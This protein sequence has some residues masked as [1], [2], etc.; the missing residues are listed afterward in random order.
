MGDTV[1]LPLEDYFNRTGM[2][3]AITLCQLPLTVTVAFIVGLALLF[4]PDTLS[5]P[6]FMPVLILHVLILG[7]CI[8][9][10]WDRL[11]AGSFVAVPM[12]DCFAIAAM[13]EVGGPVLSV[14]GLL[15]VFPVIWLSVSASRA[16]LVLAVGAPLVATI[17][18]SLAVGSG[19]ERS[20]LIRMIVFPTIMAGLAITGHVVASGL[21]RHRDKL[22]RKDRELA[23]LHE[24]TKDHAQLLDAVLETVTVGVW[25]MNT[26][27][28]DLL[29]NRRLR[30]DRSW[31]EGAVAPGQANPFIPCAPDANERGESPASLALRGANFTNRLVRVGSDNQQ[32]TFSAAARPLLD[33]SGHLKGSTIAFTDVTA[34]VEAQAARDKFVAS[35]S[36]ELRTPLTS[37]LG[38]MEVLGDGPDAHFM[39]IIERNANRLLS[40][41]NDLLLVAS[42]DLELRRRPTN[43]SELLE[44][45]A[46]AAMPAAAAKDVTI[47]TKT[48]E[49]VMAVVDPSQISKAIGHVLSNAI[50]FSPDGSPVTI[51]LQQYEGRIE[52]SVCDRGVGMTG[53]EVNQAFTKFFRGDHAMET[54]I[55]GAGL[56][57]PLS[58]AIVEAHGGTIELN[59]QPGFGTTVTITLP[60]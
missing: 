6:V 19:I 1:F 31:A 52:F 30:A 38:Y 29:T 55:P 39:G 12:V 34:L 60:E 48:P 58:K 3:R 42:E 44:E 26:E 28:E 11:P 37:I 47:A 17:A 40:L 24:A 56:G 53:Q 45:S 49:D 13:R 35:V 2:R 20:D 8:L 32:R 23:H 57:L 59:S 27:G 51:G 10:P 15:M 43:V 41:V 21:I 5:G 9:L 25:T 54:A 4:N 18:S 7:A 22:N 50:K 16:R 36:H 46:R 14:V 33:E